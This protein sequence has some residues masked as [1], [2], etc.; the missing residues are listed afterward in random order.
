MTILL[1]KEGFK[2]GLLSH[3]LIFL[4]NSFTLLASTRKKSK[5]IFDFCHVSRSFCRHKTYSGQLQFS[6]ASAGRIYEPT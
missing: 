6:W 2:R 5:L 4:K 3:N 1:S